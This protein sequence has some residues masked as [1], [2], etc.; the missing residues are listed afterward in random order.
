MSHGLNAAELEDIRSSYEEELAG[1][2]FNSKP[3]IN[4]LTTIAQENMNAAAVICKTIEDRIRSVR[5][6]WTAFLKT[7]PAV[8]QCRPLIA[9]HKFAVVSDMS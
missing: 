9:A 3:I 6:P 5:Q 4:M 1:L 2:T 7:K 8:T